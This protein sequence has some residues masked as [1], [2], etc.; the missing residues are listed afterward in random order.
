[1]QIMTKTEI[2]T[3]KSIL[4]YINPDEYFTW[5]DV[6]AYDKEQYSKQYYLKL[7]NSLFDKNILTKNVKGKTY[8][9]RV[10]N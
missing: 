5:E 6:Y 7:L 1:M 9:Y 10:N 2:N 4:L 8:H 3:L